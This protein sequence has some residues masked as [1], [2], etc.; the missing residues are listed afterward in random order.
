M[1]WTVVAIE[2]IIKSKQSQTGDFRDSV[3]SK[4]EEKKPWKAE[5]VK[6]IV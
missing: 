5:P 1:L 3:C 4:F 6:S 2:A